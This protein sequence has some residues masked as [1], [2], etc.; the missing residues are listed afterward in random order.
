MAVSI[1]LWASERG[2][3]GVTLESVAAVGRCLPTRH[4]SHIV[5]NAGHFAFLI[6]CRQA[7]AKAV[8]EIC[9][10]PP[11][12][13]RPAFHQRFNADGARVL[14]GAPSGG[15]MTF[16]AVHRP[17]AISTGAVIG[18]SFGSWTV[19]LVVSICLLNHPRSRTFVGSA[20]NP[21]F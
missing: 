18:V 16:S 9:I 4:E 13:D 21:Y 2:G 7:L 8:P 15:S 20:G 10:D 3:D 11:E 6:P 12:F 14:P 5:R 17:A 19:K 1:Q